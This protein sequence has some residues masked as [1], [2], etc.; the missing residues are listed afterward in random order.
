MI[1]LREVPS[2]IFKV[3]LKE[4]MLQKLREGEERKVSFWE[5]LSRVFSKRPVWG[6]VTVAVIVLLVVI[7]IFWGF[8][9]P[10]TQAPRPATPVPPPSP[11]SVPAAPSVPML[12]VMG[13]TERSYYLPGEEIIIEFTF[14]NDDSQP[15]IISPFPPEVNIYLPTLPEPDSKI[16]SFAAGAQ[17]LELEP[18]ETRTYSLLWDQQVIPGWYSVEVERNIRAA[19]QETEAATTVGHVTKILIR[20]PQ[21]AME[22]TIEVNQSQTLNDLTVTLEQVELSADGARFLALVTSPDYSV[23]QGAA[24]APPEWRGPVYAQYAV[25]GLTKRARVANMG[26]FEE[27][28]RLRWG[29]DIGL[30][31]VPVDARELTFTI[32]SFGDREGPWQFEIPLQRL[33]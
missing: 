19:A 6:A 31:P 29:Y 30:D 5:N 21:G 3:Q 17:E 24:L 11:V 7:W 15:L 13:D 20:Y 23:P 14:T 33:M 32:T 1:S 2:P 22:R 9:G 25:D 27:G 16:R 12:T 28:I 18:G 8:G 10:G 26:Y 4:R